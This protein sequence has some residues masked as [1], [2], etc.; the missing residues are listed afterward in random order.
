ML[1]ASDF[2]PSR[3]GGESVPASAY[4][5]RACGRALAQQRGSLFAD[6]RDSVYSHFNMHP[7]HAL[8]YSTLIFLN[9]DASEFLSKEWF[10]ELRR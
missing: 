3:S 7:L 6:F 1:D 4:G 5:L 9:D 10:E 2:R 8:T